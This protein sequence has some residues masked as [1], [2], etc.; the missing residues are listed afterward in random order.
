MYDYLIVG[1]GLA[2]I[3]FCE[4]L[5]SQG[6][7]YRVI[8]DDSQQA[9]LVAGGLYNPVILK[10][11]TMSWNAKEQMEM[12][13]PFYQHLEKKLRVKLDHKIPVLRRFASIEEQNTWFE[14]ADRPGLDY[15][16]ST[17]LIKNQNPAIDA[18]FGYGEVKYTGRIDTKTLL[19]SYVE[20]LGQKGFLQ[21]ETLDFACLETSNGHVSYKSIK[22]KRVVFAAGY[23]LKNNPFFGYLPLNGTKGELL[24][25]K[26]PDYKETHVIK[27]SVFSIPLEEDLY[28]IG[29]TY[30]W[31][32]KTNEPTEEA[33]TE[34]LEKLK[35]FLKCDFEVVGHVAGIRPTVVDRRPLVGQHPKYKNLFVLNGFGS[36]GV[37]IA[38]YASAQLFNYIENGTDLDSEINIERFTKKYYSN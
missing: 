15:F 10:R 1:L 25:I 3:S 32:D 33:K 5:E 27:S 36:R 17:Q 8:S 14:A 29:A 11:F 2:G 6:K 4:K 19:T 7:T 26:A 31:K 20:Y 13:I 23:G 38:P 30:K 24:T 16:L 9:S 34:L 18:P 37:M 21:K 22:A 35:T 28:L 12:A